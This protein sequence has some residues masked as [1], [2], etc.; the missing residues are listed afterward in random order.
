MPAD[1]R[2]VALA[3]D[4][5]ADMASR[6]MTLSVAESIT[7]GLVLASLTDV[8]GSSAVVVGGVVAYSDAV[9][10]DLL[11]LD[12]EDLARHSAVSELVAR[13]M[14]EGCRARFGT[15]VALSTTGEAGPTSATGAPV[16]THVVGVS[17]ATSTRIMSCH[18]PGDRGAVRNAAVLNALGLLAAVLGT[19]A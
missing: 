7:G 5:L 1:G 16:G 6:G 9:K 15:T 13:Q 2:A 17:T 11:G 12:V 3:A 14:A 10:V 18:A 4:L 8:P 19:D